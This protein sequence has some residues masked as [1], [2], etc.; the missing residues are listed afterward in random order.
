MSPFEYIQEWMNE[1]M[2][3]FCDLCQGKGRHV[4]SWSYMNDTC[5]AFNSKLL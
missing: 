3:T 5:L 4:T 1:W 2:I